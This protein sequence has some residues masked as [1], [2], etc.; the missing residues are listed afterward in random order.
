MARMAALVAVGALVAAA[1]G[2]SGGQ[3]ASPGTT[4]AGPGGSAPASGADHAGTSASGDGNGAGGSKPAKDTT[5]GTALPPE[6]AYNNFLVRNAKSPAE[7]GTFPKAY[8]ALALAADNLPDGVNGE[9]LAE[10]DVSGSGQFSVGE[11]ESIL[12]EAGGPVIDVDLRGESHGFLNDHAI[13]WYAPRDWSVNG[14]SKGAMLTAERDRLATLQPGSTVTVIDGKEKVS[15][16]YT[17]GIATDIEVERVASEEEVIIGKGHAYE[18]ITAIDHV[19]MTPAELDQVVALYQRWRSVPGTR[20]HVHCAGGD[21]RTTTVLAALDMLANATKLSAEDIVARQA[22][23]GEG[24]HL[25][26][27]G[28]P[29]GAFYYQYVARAEQMRS[30]YAYAKAHPGGE[31]M[32]YSSWLAAGR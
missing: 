3:G 13:S 14:L 2:C 12:A 16:S 6:V 17:T 8:R 18:R 5:G 26:S 15:G 11:L 30:F 9:G 24:T 27:T 28:K 25:F 4:I 21:G 19:P 29:D 20:L 22:K 23:L 31:G 10:L 1:A 32:T 7:K